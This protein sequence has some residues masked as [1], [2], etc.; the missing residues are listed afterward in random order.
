MLSSWPGPTLL[1]ADEAGPYSS[2]DG[3]TLAAPPLARDAAR[4][5]RA[6]SDC[7]P[8]IRPTPSSAAASYGP[9]P[10]RVSACCSAGATRRLTPECCRAGGAPRAP[11]RPK[12]WLGPC[13][14]GCRVAALSATSTLA[15]TTDGVRGSLTSTKLAPPC[16]CFGSPSRACERTLDSGTHDRSSVRPG[17]SAAAPLL[18]GVRLLGRLSSF[19]AGS[20]GRPAQN[21]PGSAPSRRRRCRA[22]GA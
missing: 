12:P 14:P 11:P 21:P 16:A 9:S 2:A 13:S 6:A 20:A 5:S 17:A 15:V 19:T 1:A 8:L 7:R 10:L 4:P 22:C 18:P 3:C